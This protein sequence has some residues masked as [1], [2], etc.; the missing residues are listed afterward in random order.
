M[1][2]RGIINNVVKNAIRFDHY[3]DCLQ[4]NV[5][6]V[7]FQRYIRAYVYNHQTFC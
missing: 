4:E 3:L 7:A 1:Y 5:Q 6:N 2:Q